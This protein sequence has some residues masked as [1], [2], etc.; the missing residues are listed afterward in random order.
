MAD[1]KVLRGNRI[2]VTRPEK[3]EVKVILSKEQQ[4]AKDAEDLVKHT[5]LT[6]YAVGDLVTDINV[7]DEILAELSKGLV[8]KIGGKDRILLSVFDVILVW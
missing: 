6:V 4:D 1:F 2:L 8:Y 7:G 3:D 5:R